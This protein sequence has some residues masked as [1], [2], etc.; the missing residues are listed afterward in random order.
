MIIEK[1]KEQNKAMKK[2]NKGWNERKETDRKKTN[3]LNISSHRRNTVY[4]E[5]ESEPDHRTISNDFQVCFRH[6][7][8]LWII[9]CKELV[10][11]VVTAEVF[12]NT[13]MG[14]FVTIGYSNRV[15]LLAKKSK[16]RT[17]LK[18]QSSKNHI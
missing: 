10:E 2:Q 11:R 16:K 14:R 6:Y 7:C 18:L 12:N 9:P 17:I 8:G 4:V 5:K 15:T 1:R 13:D 3:G